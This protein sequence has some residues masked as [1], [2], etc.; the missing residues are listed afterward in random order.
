MALSFDTHGKHL[1]R[2]GPWGLGRKVRGM[3]K[4]QLTVVSKLWACSAQRREHSQ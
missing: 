4:H 3:K 1:G 2:V